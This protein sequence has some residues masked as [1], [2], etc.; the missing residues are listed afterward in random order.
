[1]KKQIFLLFVIFALSSVSAL[2]VTAHIPEKYQEVVEGE[3]IYFE[4]AIKYP[5]NPTRIDLRFEYEVRDSTGEI[6]ASAKALKAVETQASFIDFIVLPEEMSLG[7]YS[8]DIH[9]KDYGDLSEEV[10]T[11]FSVAKS[12]IDRLYI[13]V[14]GLIVAVTILSVLILVIALKKK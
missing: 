7:S 11:S 5:E 13:M 6:V 14:Y 10:G 12:E 4:L 8:L 9:I 1:M 3:R 2:S